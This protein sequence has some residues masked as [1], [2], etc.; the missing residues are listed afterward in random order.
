MLRERLRKVRERVKQAC[1]R[2]GRD[3]QS[4]TLIAVSKTF[5]MS[6]VLEA[7][8]AGIRHF[9][10]NRVQELNEKSKNLPGVVNNGDIYWHMIGHA[11]RNKAKD[12]VSNADMM[13]SLDSVRLASELNKRA[14]GLRD[15]IPCMIQVNVSGESSK[16]GLQPQEVEGFLEEI[17]EF[18]HIDPTGLM[19]LAA[20]AKNPEDIRPQFTLLRSLRDELGCKYAS[21]K[22]LSMGMSGDFEVA[23]EEGATHVRIGSLL[24]GSRY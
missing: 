7:Y 9:G 1:E 3:E 2:A 18:E 19:T 13:H 16:F 21:I 23:I 8:Q 15:K 11:Q 4:V 6:S 5:P 10:E 20:P 17:R 12:I 24:F 22:N 14:S